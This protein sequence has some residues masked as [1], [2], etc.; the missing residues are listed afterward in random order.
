M[1]QRG[2]E[3][4]E[5]RDVVIKGTIIQV[6]TTYRAVR[7]RSYHLYASLENYTGA[8]HFFCKSCLAD[9]I[10]LSLSTGGVEGLAFDDGPLGVEMR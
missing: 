4:P 7:C 3:L 6:R 10:V 5:A 9:S 8:S 1:G 2:E